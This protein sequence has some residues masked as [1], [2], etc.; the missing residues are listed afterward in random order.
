M[1]IGFGATYEE[2]EEE[3]YVFKS[4]VVCPSCSDEFSNYNIPN[5]ENITTLCSCEN[6]EIGF[7]NS[8]DGKAARIGGVPGFITVRYKKEYPKFVDKDI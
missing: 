7:L 3:V 8:S 4:F 5:D 2:N 1:K 6:L